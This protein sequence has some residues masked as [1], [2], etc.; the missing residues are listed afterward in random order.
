MLS[1]WNLT[2]HE[3]LISRL[4]LWLTLSMILVQITVQ[5]AQHNIIFFTLNVRKPRSKNGIYKQLFILWLGI[6]I[7]SLRPTSHF[8][9]VCYKFLSSLVNFW[10]P[11]CCLSSQ[12]LSKIEIH[13]IWILLCT[14]LVH[15]KLRV[16]FKFSFTKYF[17]MYKHAFKKYACS[18]SR[19]KGTSTVSV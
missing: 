16:Y 17:C 8:M 13:L 5:T 14:E 15:E 2:K 9:F 1:Q 4:F 18:T 19:K 6:E 10:I 7:L 12:T 11:L 3:S